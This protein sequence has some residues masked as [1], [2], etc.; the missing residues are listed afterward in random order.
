VRCR[1]WNWKVLRSARLGK[2]V[3]KPGS[4]NILPRRRQNM[5]LANGPSRSETEP[6]RPRS[7]CYNRRVSA[8][9]VVALGEKSTGPA[10]QRVLCLRVDETMIFWDIEGPTVEG[11]GTHILTFTRW[12]S[13]PPS[14]VCLSRR[15]GA[16]SIWWRGWEPGGSRAGEQ[17][18]LRR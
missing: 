6:C 4:R 3:A 16:S 17:A 8:T 12:S 15:A 14:A 2:R 9:Q 11:G 18:V 13:H 7:G 5:F 1:V 10:L